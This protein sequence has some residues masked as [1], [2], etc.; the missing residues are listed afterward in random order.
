MKDNN[1][2]SYM[3]DEKDILNGLKSYVLLRYKKDGLKTL[4]ISSSSRG[5]SKTWVAINLASAFAFANYKTLLVDL[6]L[7]SP[8]VD[9]KLN[10]KKKTG[11]TDVA[12][13]VINLK[14]AIINYD[15]KLDI[16]LSGSKIKYIDQFLNSNVLSNTVNNIAKEYDILVINNS[17]ITSVEDCRGIENYADSMILCI[18]ENGSSKYDLKRVRDYITESEINLLGIIMTNTIDVKEEKI[19]EVKLDNVVFDQEEVDFVDNKIKKNRF[20]DKPEETTEKVSKKEVSTKKVTPKAKKV[21]K[22]KVVKKTE[23][24]KSTKAKAVSK[25]KTKKVAITKPVAKKTASAKKPA[26]KAKNSKLATTQLSQKERIRMA[27]AKQKH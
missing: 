7:K 12:G 6:D 10:L 4:S 23:P 20:L 19:E 3:K 25:P 27:L 2:N 16:L 1:L 11:I 8:G 24:K 22:K 17:P 5:E 18:G 21:E 15:K 13:K 26:T 9:V 14:D